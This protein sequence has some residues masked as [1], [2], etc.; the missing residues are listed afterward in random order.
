MNQHELAA[1]LRDVGNSR[2]D[3]LAGRLALQKTVRLLQ[4]LGV[5]L[6]Y[7]FTRYLH[8]PYCRALAKDGYA[9]R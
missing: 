1:I 3:D 6:G 4:A 9:P 5:N 8:G 7:R 2:V